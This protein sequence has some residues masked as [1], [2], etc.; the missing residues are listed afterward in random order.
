MIQVDLIMMIKFLK[1]FASLVALMAV[2][3]LIAGVIIYFGDG[4]EGFTKE[5]VDH[6]FRFGLA[7]LFGCACAAAGSILE[8]KLEERSQRRP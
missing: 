1:S 3:F 4:R 5:K 6:Y 2:L 8:A 7:T